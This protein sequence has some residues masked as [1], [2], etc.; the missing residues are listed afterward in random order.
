M[1]NCV[2]YL[3]S[4][5]DIK[6]LLV[7]FGKETSNNLIFDILKNTNLNK[8]S[9]CITDEK[10]LENFNEEMTEFKNFYDEKIPKEIA[11]I[12]YKSIKQYKKKEKE[13]AILIDSA[14]NISIFND[15]LRLKPY[16]LLATV[17]K[18]KVSSFDVWSAFKECS[19]YI[20]IHSWRL[21]Q[22]DEVLNWERN[23]DTNIELSVIFPVYNVGKYLEK[24]LSSISEWPANYVE[25]LF[26]DDGSTDNGAKIINKFSKN[27]KRIKY[28]KKKNGGCASARQFGLE[29]ANGRYVGFIDP[30]DYIDPTMYHKL[31]SR[32][33]EG[34]YDI[35]YCGYNELYEKTGTIQCIEDVLG[36]PYDIG[37]D[38]KEFIDRLIKDRRVAIWRGIYRKDMIDNNNIHFYTDIRRFDD[39]PFKVETLA[40]ANSV[41]CI[42]EYL[43]YYRM[44]RPGQDVSADDERLYVHFPIFKYLDEF[45]NKKGKQT[46][47]EYLQIVKISTHQWALEK[48][49][50]EYVKHYVNEARKDLLSNM[51]LNEGKLIIKKYSTKRNYYLSLAI[52][53]NLPRIAKWLADYKYREDKKRQEQLMKLRKLSV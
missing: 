28:Y 20:Y 31:F 24:C 6:E 3:T 17:D 27:D 45:M 22:R 21:N 34:S 46:Q 41:V 14:L 48:I 13:L 32:A 7:I 53:Y 18:K 37:T 30:D 4:K 15:V 51:P 9:L 44:S 12:K 8:I 2:E 26:I 23:K 36:W 10:Q 19:E 52:Y 35:S 43:Y 40:V 5:P 29:K 39:L 49:K 25:Y 16:W 1:I 50:K 42:P 38:D 47:I 33:M 11:T